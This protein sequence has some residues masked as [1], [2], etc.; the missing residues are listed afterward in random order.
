VDAVLL[1]LYGLVFPGLLFLI[2]YAFLLEYVDRKL[3]AR[4]QS[5]VG[6]PFLQP[7]ADFVKL[8]AKEDVTPEGADGPALRAIPVLAFA[9][10]ATAFLYVPVLGPS[11]FAFQGD[12]IVV[13]YLLT[14]PTILTFLLGWLSRN[15]FA[16]IGG[17]R[18]ITQLFVYEVPLFVALL[19]PAIAAGTWSVS[20]VAAAQ[21]G[22]TW[23][24]A[25][26]PVGLAVA[27]IAFQAKLE[28]APFDLPEAETEIVAGP[29][30]E[31][32]GRK[33]ALARLT[34]D[35]TVVAGCALVAAV[36]LGG[37]T[38]PIDVAPGIPGLALGFAAFL[39]KTLGLLVLL[40]VGKAAMGRVRMDQLNRFGWTYLTGAAIAQLALV[41][42]LA[43]VGIP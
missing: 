10:V 21:A 29:W 20:G 26:Q 28:R 25:F 32:T 4:M 41:L 43:G 31:L 42:V 36:F 17:V 5:R 8:L 38:L 9:A 24:A 7:F 39:G 33:L 15:V 30:T 23:A 19:G 40:S 1:V 13:L 3:V 34:A 27:L 6:P 11:P 2:G 37:P 35:S 12:L 22:G 18:A 14:L 16:T